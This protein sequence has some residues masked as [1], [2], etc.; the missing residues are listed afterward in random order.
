MHD[1]AGQAP[2]V[3]GFRIHNLSVDIEAQFAGDQ[4]S[5]LFMG[6]GMRRDHGVLSYLELAHQCLFTM[7][8]CR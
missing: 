1:A 4:H 8:Q 5:G 7:D 6:M 3:S 2:A